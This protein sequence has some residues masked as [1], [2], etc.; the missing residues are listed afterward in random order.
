MENE[1]YY[2]HRVNSFGPLTN[3]EWLWVDTIAVNTALSTAA[4]APLV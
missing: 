1:C 3:R 4:F 2:I